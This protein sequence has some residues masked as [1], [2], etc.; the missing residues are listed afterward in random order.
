M[1]EILLISNDQICLKKKE[2]SSNYNDTVNIIEA[3][4]K[5]YNIFLISEKSKSKKNFLIKF[6][7][8][9][10]SINLKFLFILKKKKF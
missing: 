1:R 6:K 2:I 5:A 8:K 3:I 9:I 4:S 7:N 10:T